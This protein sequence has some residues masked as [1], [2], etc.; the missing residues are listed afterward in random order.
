M[1]DSAKEGQWWR[2]SFPPWNTLRRVLP[3][4]GSTS[5][6]HHHIPGLGKG[7]FLSIWIP[8]DHIP[9]LASFSWHSWGLHPSLGILFLAFLR[10]SSLSWYPSPGIPRDCITLL[11][12]PEA[13]SCP[14]AA[15]DVPAHCRGLAFQDPFQPKLFCASV[16]PLQTSCSQHPS[17]GI[18]RDCIPFLAFPGAASRSVWCPSF[19]QRGW[20]GWPLKIPSNPRYSVIL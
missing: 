17:P 6:S 18:P 19:L 20:T 12:S 1:R 11:A 3:M 5:V 4:M 14:D 7:M 8:R 9:L 13:A 2:G 10:T 16:I 15:E